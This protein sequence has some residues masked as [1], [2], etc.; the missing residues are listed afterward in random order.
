MG[1]VRHSTFQGVLTNTKSPTFL[2][3]GCA[4]LTASVQASLQFS[5]LEAPPDLLSSMTNCLVSVESRLAPAARF[6]LYGAAAAVVHKEVLATIDSGADVHI[7]TYEAALILFEDIKASRLQVVGVNGTGSRADVRGQLVITV[8]SQNG[9]I[10]RF[11]LGEAHGMKGCPMNL[12]SLSLL[13]DVGAIIHFERGDC[14]LQPPGTSSKLDRVPLRRVGGLFQVPVSKC[15][16]SSSSSSSSSA[17]RQGVPAHGFGF[18]GARRPEDLINDDDSADSQFHSFAANGVSFLSGDLD[19]WHRRMRHF[20]KPKLKRIWSLG[21]VDG[22]HLVG[23][24]NPDCRCDVCVQAKIRAQPSPTYSKAPP[25]T[26]AIGEHVSTDV[27]S[28]SYQSFEGFKYVINFVDHHTRLGFCYMMRNKSESAA[29]FALY[30]SELKFYGFR[31]QHLHSDRGSEYFSQEG[32]LMARHEDRAFAALDT[33]CNAQSPIIKHRLTP[34]AAKEK[35][36]EAWF[37]DH[38][39]AADAMLWEARLSPAF[40]ADAILYSQFVYNH[41]PNDHT[42]SATPS[43]L[44]TGRPSRWDKFRVFGSDCYHLIPNDPISKIP[45]IVKGRKA[46]FVGFTPNLNGYRVFHPETRSYATV[47]NV[48]F[49]ENMKHRIDSLRHHDRRR[50]LMLSDKSQPVQLNDFDDV[51]AGNGVRNLFTSPDIIDPQSSSQLPAGEVPA[52]DKVVFDSDPLESDDAVLIFRPSPAVQQSQPSRAAAEPVDQPPARE[53]PPDQ[54]PPITGADP[55]MPCGVHSRYESDAAEETV[56]SPTPPRRALSQDG[57]LADRAR[58]L[59]RTSEVLR[60]VRLLPVGVESL[61]TVDDAKFLRHARAFDIPVSYAPNPKRAKTIAARRYDKYSKATT[62]R[63][64]LELGASQGDLLWDYRRAFIRFPKHES[65]EPGHIFS[66]IQTAA[67]NGHTHILEDVG[68]YVSPTHH[69]DFMLAKAFTSSKMETAKFV[70]NDLLRSCFDPEALPRAIATQGAALDFAE[71]QFAKVL[72]VKK[73]INI[74]WSLAAEPTRWEQT[75]PEVCSES[76]EWKEAMD[77]EITSMVKFGVFTRMPRSAAGRRQILGCRWVFKRKTNRFGE[78]YRYRARLVAQGF[79]QRAYDSYDPDHTSSPVVHKDTLRLF[80]SVCAAENLRVFQA[81]VKAAFL[82]AP[83]EEEIF[84]KA[85]PG[86]DSIDPETGEPTVWRLSK[87]IYGLKQSSACFWSALCKHLTDH[88]FV[89]ILG[90]PCLFKKVMPDGGVIM[91]ASYVDDLTFA[92]SDQSQHSYFM[93]LMRARFEIDEGEG[94]PVEWLLG[95]AIQQ[96]LEAGFIRMDMETAITKL[97]EGLLTKE[98]LAKASSIQHPMLS[99][100][101]LPKLSEAEI[102]VSEFDYLSVVGSLLHIANCVRCDISFAVGVLSRH[103]MHPGKA[104]VRACKRVVQYLFNTRALGI[105]YRRP[106]ADVKKHVPL[107]FEGAQH[108]LDDGTNKLQVFADSDYAADHTRR[109]THGSVTM[110]NGGPISWS[111]TLGKTVATSTC[112]AEVNAAVFAA[113]D[114]IHINRLLLDL[115]VVTKVPLQIAEDNSACIAQANNGLRAVR[116]AKHYEIKLAFLQQLI[117][118]KEIEFVYCPTDL[119]LADFFTKPLDEVK[120]T[121]FRKDFLS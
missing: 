114:A 69:A 39:R 117:V 85:P 93:D 35:L 99:T 87:A 47:D 45:G 79:R 42:G 15:T 26:R 37:L 112:E 46:I 111:S 36:A 82:Q 40:W 41:L 51:I 105:T 98:E 2:F 84:I 75:L 56:A 3:V 88:G 29:C 22:F 92:V 104:H 80:L 58:Q 12:L 19:L 59:L 73:G 34:V 8:K 81:D 74:D 20:S 107:M 7:L 60:P 113:K 16:P 44:L 57:L 96:D 10:H 28:L 62:L 61:Y 55:A 49:Y 9:L 110:M 115:N 11:Y 31:V 18:A 91:V 33:Y 30:C 25:T 27:K 14:Y 86:Y 4:Q 38:F 23:N 32:P 71:A 48:Y 5:L 65:D 108:P 1:S 21:L 106:R 54:P 109:S 83:L 102:N 77:D 101:Q 43:Q 13:L 118:D 95:M 24:T 76:D 70:F 90:D 100:S 53:P 68:K 94:A 119:Q 17:P 78:V 116:N 52:G 72:N 97:A 63:G 6:G 66:A 120:F 50:D 64:A 67:D 103:G 89:S 121:G